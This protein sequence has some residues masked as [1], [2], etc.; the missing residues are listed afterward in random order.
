MDLSKKGLLLIFLVLCLIIA[1][2]NISSAASSDEKLIDS[3]TQVDLKH[4]G[5]TFIYNAYSYGDNLVIL[6]TAMKCKDKKGVYKEIL[7]IQTDGQKIMID[8]SYI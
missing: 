5:I 3:R 6:H 4:P 8:T 7:T 1:P 2:I